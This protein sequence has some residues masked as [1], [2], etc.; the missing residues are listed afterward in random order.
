VEFKRPLAAAIGR[1]VFEQGGRRE[2]AAK[3]GLT[4][5]HQ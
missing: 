1:F 2:V 4:A 5:K 3:V